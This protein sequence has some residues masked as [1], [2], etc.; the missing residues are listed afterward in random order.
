MELLLKTVGLGVKHRKTKKGKGLAGDLLKAGA[1]IVGKKAIE[2]GSNYLNNKLD[3]M[4]VKKRGRPCGGS[5]FPA[6]MG[7]K[8]KSWR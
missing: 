3:E 1:K 7:L 4:G 2:A 6:G 8:I 5:L